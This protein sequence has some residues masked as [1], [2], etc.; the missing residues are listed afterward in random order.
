MRVGV[1]DV[2]MEHGHVA[3]EPHRPDAGLVEQSGQ[4]LLEVGDQRDPAFR[5]PTGRAIA[6]LARCIA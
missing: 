6:S 1:L 4:L 5:E 3:A 2:H